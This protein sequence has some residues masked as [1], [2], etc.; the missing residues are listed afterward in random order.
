MDTQAG[1]LFQSS[2]YVTGVEKILNY[3]ELASRILGVKCPENGFGEGWQ[4][5]KFNALSTIKLMK[6]TEKE[7]PRFGDLAKFNISTEPSP[8]C[9]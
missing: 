5:K 4:V 9:L 7:R 2:N 8:P 3:D 6:R 1:S